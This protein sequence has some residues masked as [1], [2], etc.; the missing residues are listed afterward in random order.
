MQVACLM[1]S[2]SCSG[3]GVSAV[4]RV[5]VPFVRRPLLAWGGPVLRVERAVLVRAVDPLNVPS[6]SPSSE[7]SSLEES[8]STCRVRLRFFRDSSSTTSLKRANRKI[9][10]A[11]NASRSSTLFESRDLACAVARRIK[12]SSVRTVNGDVLL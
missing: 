4:F 6:L 2:R 5:E 10:S 9:A 3:S 1:S 11:A 8:D 7:L 12:V